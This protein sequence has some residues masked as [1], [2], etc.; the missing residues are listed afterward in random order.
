MEHRTDLY[1]QPRP[2]EPGRMGMQLLMLLSNVPKKPSSR[3]RSGNHQ[4]WSAE[5]TPCLMRMSIFAFC[6]H[7]PY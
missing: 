6:L 1:E 7:E 5:T 4:P 3:S 2:V